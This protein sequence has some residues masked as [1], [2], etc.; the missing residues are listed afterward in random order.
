MYDIFFE[1]DHQLFRDSLRAYLKK[2]IVPHLEHWET[3]EKVDRSA[4][5]AMAEQ[6]YFSLDIPESDGGLGLNF[7]YPAILCEEIGRIGSLGFQTVVGGHV[8]LAMNYL[9]HAGS[10][11]LKEKYLAPS[12]SGAIVGSLSMTEPNTGSDLKAIK[13]T[14][15]LS[16]D[17]YVVNGAKTFISNG[18]YGD[19]TVA[20][21]K[22]DGKISLLVIDLN[23]EGVTKTKLNKLGIKSSDTAE[24]AFD[25]VKV[26]KKNLLGEA[27][28][29]FYYMMESLQVE[30]MSGVL[31][32]IGLMDHVLDMTLKYMSEREAFEK[33]L[34]KFQALRHKIAEIATEID[35]LKSFTYLT[36][37]RLAKGENVVKECSMLK[38]KTAD[39]MNEMV[40]DC[41]QM[42][43][44]YG[45]MEDYPI[46]RLYR[47]VR[48]LSIYAGTSEIMKEIIAKMVI[49]QLEYKP[50]Y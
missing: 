27:G 36:T 26:P 41:L 30:R 6:G 17:Y 45:Y 33:Q 8:F 14:A 25:N 10:P 20:A 7:M 34:V 24:I 32:T 11:Y 23:A 4:L 43:G 38:L 28:K 29:G 37:Y 48:V 22:I 21:V 35:S 42:F 9:I 13:T 47:D 2:E 1:E 50:V 31:F 12:M 39:F 3:Q 49:D 15:L 46:A 44:G 19:Y 16:N 5:K 40:Y 18:Y